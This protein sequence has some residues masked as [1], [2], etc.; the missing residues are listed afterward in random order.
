MDTSGAVD[1]DTPPSKDESVYAELT[2]KGEPVD[3]SR[4]FEGRYSHGVPCFTQFA[5][6]GCCSSHC[7]GHFY[8]HMSDMIGAIAP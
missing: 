5:Q 6:F 7:G 1:S 3:P 2:G 8:K 4:L